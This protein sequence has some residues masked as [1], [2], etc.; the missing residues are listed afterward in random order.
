[1]RIVDANAPTDIEQFWLNIGRAKALAVAA[2]RRDGV[3]T[4]EESQEIVAA[5]GDSPSFDEAA[6]KAFALGIGRGIDELLTRMDASKR[7]MVRHMLLCHVAESSRLTFNVQGER[8]TVTRKTVESYDHMG[9]IRTMTEE[10]VK[11]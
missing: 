7:S 11:I 5:L 2:G 1:M 9:R 4:V 3:I 10:Q 6:Q 8:R